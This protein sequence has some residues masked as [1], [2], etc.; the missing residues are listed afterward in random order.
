MINL[1]VTR[2]SWWTGIWA[3]VNLLNAPLQTLQ[4]LHRKYGDVVSFSIRGRNWYSFNH[5][6]AIREILLH[7]AKF[8]SR[9]PIL[10]R[11]RAIMGNGLVT[12]EEAFH[13]EH[14][15]SLNQAFLQSNFA[16][17]GPKIESLTI[18]CVNS[19]KVGK[20]INLSL[21]IRRL[22][23]RVIAL[24]LF[25]VDIE[26]EIDPETENVI[27]TDGAFAVSCLRPF[28]SSFLRPSRFKS[29][30]SRFL[31]AIDNLMKC[32]IARGCE[33]D[34]LFSHLFRA[35]NRSSAEN[36]AQLR[37]MRDDLS[38]LLLAG[39]HTTAHALEWTF[40]LLDRHPEVQNQLD[41]FSTTASLDDH[42]Y[43]TTSMIQNV[44]NEAIRLYPPLWIMG[45][46]VEEE[47]SIL[48]VQLSHGTGVVLSPWVTHRDSRWFSEPDLFI[49]SRWSNTSLNGAEKAFFPFG[50][51]PRKCIG[52]RLSMFE[53]EI[54]LSTIIKH[55]RLNLIESESVQPD[56]GFTLKPF[57]D[58]WVVPELKYAC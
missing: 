49:P 20:R 45:R 54:V 11:A 28:R 25:D 37:Q 4:Q 14:R 7:K 58:L 17:Y 1:T 52:D 18:R 22:M 35:N 32:R 46:L 48:N 55:C 41:R 40:W 56:P 50:D 9:P 44:L 39:H 12:C 43:D 13:R 21:E 19:W 2:L 42:G 24:L 23:L 38:T 10:K 30:T 53:S 36:T 47:T 8:F 29:A 6:D 57:P 15:N 31:S 26:E 16:Q 33:G 27:L 3:S 34:D 51:G 5:P